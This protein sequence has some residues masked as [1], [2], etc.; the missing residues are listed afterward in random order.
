MTEIARA[1]QHM[2]TLRLW[3]AALAEFAL[4]RPIK[5]A[6][7]TFTGALCVYAA[8]FDPYGGED[9]NSV[10]PS[11]RRFF[12]LVHVHKSA[13][14]TLCGLAAASGRG[15][16]HGHFTE[17]MLHANCNPYV[18][19]DDDECS[20]PRERWAIACPRVDDDGTGVAGRVCGFA[21]GPDRQNPWMRTTSDALRVAPR[22]ACNAAFSRSTTWVREIPCTETSRRVAEAPLWAMTRAEQLAFFRDVACERG[23]GLVANERFLPSEFVPPSDG[24]TYVVVLRDPVERLVSHWLHDSSFDKDLPAGTNFSEWW[25]GFAVHNLATRALCGGAE[26]ALAAHTSRAHFEAAA[27][28]LRH[29]EVIL[30]ELLEDGLRRLE[31]LGWAGAAARAATTVGESR[32]AGRRRLEFAAARPEEDAAVRAR[33]RWDVSLY[34]KG[35]EAVCAALPPATRAA[36]RECREERQCARRGRRRLTT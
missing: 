29:M 24:V 4:E 16:A 30:L 19:V 21:T 10:C 18:F 3:L 14:S 25:R 13:G 34:A 8:I 26:C 27:A 12:Y 15:S 35:A 2:A 23:G 36:R 1:L 11:G 17:G 28:R 31:A 7:F 20:E 6:I 33:N 32:G 5:S 9:P 22:C